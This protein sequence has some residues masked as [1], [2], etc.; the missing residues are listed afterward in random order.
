MAC[1]YLM[2]DSQPGRVGTVF[3]LDITSLR[4][5]Y[6]PTGKIDLSVSINVYS[7]KKS[8]TR[9]YV[10]KFERERKMQ[11]VLR[12]FSFLSGFPKAFLY[13]QEKKIQ[14]IETPRL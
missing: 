13:E 9:V 10:V 12:I 4:C 8:Y 7:E 11:V 1:R 14:G 2:V 6:R 5:Y 3:C